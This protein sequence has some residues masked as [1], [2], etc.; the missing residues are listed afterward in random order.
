LP[1]LLRVL[2]LGFRL[3]FLPRSLWLLPRLQVTPRC[4]TLILFW[5]D[6]SYQVL[7]LRKNELQWLPPDAA[8]MKSMQQLIVTGIC[9]H[10]FFFFQE[11]WFILFDMCFRQSFHIP[12]SCPPFEA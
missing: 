3:K 10:N 1:Q 12:A 8:K 7:S 9:S 5:I 11:K 4:A 6:V 2:I